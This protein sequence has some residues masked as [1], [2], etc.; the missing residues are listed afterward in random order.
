ML[1]RRTSAYNDKTTC[2]IRH[3]R[4]GAQEEGTLTFTCGGPIVLTE[5]PYFILCVPRGRLNPI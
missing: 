3:T 5:L 4:L 2:N 1:G